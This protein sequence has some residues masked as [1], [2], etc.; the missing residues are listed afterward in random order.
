MNILWWLYGILLV[1]LY[2]P[3][4]YLHEASHASLYHANGFRTKIVPILH[5]YYKDSEDSFLPHYYFP[6]NKRFWNKKY[7]DF[8]F[9]G[10]YETR[11]ESSTTPSNAAYYWIWKAPSL[12][13]TIFVLILASYMIHSEISWCKTLFFAIATTNLI[14]LCINYYSLFLPDKKNSNNWRVYHNDHWKAAKIGNIPLRRARMNAIAFTG[15]PL[16]VTILGLFI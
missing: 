15:P 1:I 6:W 2:I 3:Q 5:R 7:G 9:A 4:N 12:I 13:N 10:L 11:L 16:I 8:K 14:D